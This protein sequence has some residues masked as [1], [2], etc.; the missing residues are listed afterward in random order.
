MLIIIIA[1][2]QYWRLIFFSKVQLIIPSDHAFLLMVCE[3]NPP[4][5]A[6]WFKVH[7]TKNC[8][9]GLILLIYALTLD[10]IDNFL[11]VQHV[12][13][14]MVYNFVCLFV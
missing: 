1:M 4:P 7:D 10:Q 3:L 9:I 5:L 13:G 8:A 2:K 11:K 14:T 12:Q 6:R